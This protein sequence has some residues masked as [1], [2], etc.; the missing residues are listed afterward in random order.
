MTRC[1]QTEQKSPLRN[2]REK[3]RKSGEDTN[4]RQYVFGREVV[5]GSEITGR[6]LYL[7]MRLHNNLYVHARPAFVP[8]ACISDL[9]H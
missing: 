2:Q 6:H 7:N 1:H 5:A 8:C 9:D 4:I 3:R